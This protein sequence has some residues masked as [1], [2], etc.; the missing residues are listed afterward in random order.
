[1]FLNLKSANSKCK[2]CSF[3]NHYGM[4]NMYFKLYDFWSKRFGAACLY[5]ILSQV[6]VTATSL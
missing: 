2:M 6:L 1:M 3:S 5:A 4:T